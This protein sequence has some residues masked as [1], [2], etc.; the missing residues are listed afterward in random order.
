MLL[1]F[2]CMQNSMQHK[3]GGEQQQVKDL[4]KSLWEQQLIASMAEETLEEKVR[5]LYKNL[6]GDSQQH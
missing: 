2:H 4:Y 3:E 5:H 1:L 6:W